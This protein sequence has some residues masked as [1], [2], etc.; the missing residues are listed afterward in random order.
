MICEA[1][2]ISPNTVRA[3]MRSVFAKCDVDSRADLLRLI[4]N[5]PAYLALRRDARPEM[6][7]K[8][9]HPHYQAA[10]IPA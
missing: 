1:M 3:H 8:S 4:I 9:R 7:S 5:S 6:S 2:G 10:C